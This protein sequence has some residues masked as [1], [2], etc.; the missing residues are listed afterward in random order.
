MLNI[1]TLDGFTFTKLEY[2]ALLDRYFSI[3]NYQSELLGTSFDGHNIYG[4]KLGDPTKPVM[5]IEANIHG[6]HEWRTCYWVSEFM[7]LLVD[8]DALPQREIFD[9]LTANYCFYFIPSVNPDG[10]VNNNYRNGNMVSISENF[11]VNWGVQTALPG[12]AEYPGPYPWSEPESR[13]V[14]DKILELKPLSVLCLHTWGSHT[15]FTTR[16]PKNRE[17]TE[18]LV[19]FYKS[20]NYTLGYDSSFD[21]YLSMILDTASAYNWAGEQ[22]SKN[23]RKTFGQVFET[24]GN[25]SEYEQSKMGLNGILYHCLYV[26]NLFKTG[27]KTFS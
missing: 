15:G 17:Y 12:A 7:K 8:H 25:S 1:P 21:T 4:F 11:D 16:Y 26:D 24:G 19:N 10:Y 9:Y 3:P 23:G 22:T 2:S 13:I 14:R 27:N 20:L 6:L 18:T 5:Y